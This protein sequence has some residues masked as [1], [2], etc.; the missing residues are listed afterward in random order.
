MER[1]LTEDDKAVGVGLVGGETIKA[2]WVISAADGHATIYEML[3]SRFVDTAIEKA[4][5]TR[6]LFPAYLQVS[7]GVA[8]DLNNQP[9]QTTRLLKTPLQVDPETALSQVTFR[10]F[11][12]DPTFAPAEKTAVTCFLPTRNSSYWMQL[13]RDHPEEYRA[14]KR[15]V[16]LSVI[17]VLE[18]KLP[19]LR[20]AIDI[21]DV[22]TPATVVRYTGNWKGSMEGW[23]PTPQTGFKSLPKTLP[24][25]RNFF[26]IGQWT[27]PGGGLP[28][29]LLSA[30]P[31]IAA[32][33]KRDGVSFRPR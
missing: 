27:T 31:A 18:K 16:A 11:N 2:D 19:G 9:A 12:F 25:L 5:Q 13:R 6:E 32:I 7:L 24:G 3:D 30:R 14:E 10:I 20:A 4:Y 21:I 22:A 23:L 33:C 8:L 29:G 28:S 1:I 15:R 26:M 17:D